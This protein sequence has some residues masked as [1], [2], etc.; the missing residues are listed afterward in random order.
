[1]LKPTVPFP[2]PAAPVVTVIH[3]TPLTAVH[4]HAAVVV[5]V[6]VPVLAV[7]GAV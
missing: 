4:E 1:M 7:A 5:T 6:S 3:G 2:V